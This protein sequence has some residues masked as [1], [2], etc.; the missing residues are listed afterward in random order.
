MRSE[1]VADKKIWVTETG[2]V[3]EPTYAGRRLDPGS[4]QKQAEQLEKAYIQANEAGVER[5]FWLLLKDRREPYFG[6]MGLSDMRGNR[7]PAW[8]VHKRLAKS[9][10]R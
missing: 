7:R 10:S 6:S 2:F 3:S 9:R 5:V 1:G 8:F 4:L